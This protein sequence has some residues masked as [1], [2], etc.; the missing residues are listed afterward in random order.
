MK[1]TTEIGRGS[2][3]MFSSQFRW[4]SALK[5]N[6]VNKIQHRN[7]K[8]TTASLNFTSYILPRGSYYRLLTPASCMTIAL[9]RVRM[10]MPRRNIQFPDTFAPTDVYRDYKRK[11][12]VITD[13]F[14]R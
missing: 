13:L 8:K 1:S 7:G 4:N 14:K 3:R 5:S 11:K 2:N 6:I 12:S 9:I 10:R